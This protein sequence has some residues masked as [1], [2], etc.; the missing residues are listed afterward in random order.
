MPI[1]KDNPHA[2]SSVTRD[3]FSLIPLMPAGIGPTMFSTT[4]TDT[5]GNS[6]SKCGYTQEKADKKAGDAFND[7]ERGSMNKPS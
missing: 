4:V 2:P 3:S 1:D 5:E 6:V 7:G